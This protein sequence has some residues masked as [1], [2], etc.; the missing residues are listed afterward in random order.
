MSQPAAAVFLDHCKATFRQNIWV[1]LQDDKC[2][3]AMGLH[4][5]ER[6]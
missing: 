2:S 1:N 5:T 4:P 6:F 3:P